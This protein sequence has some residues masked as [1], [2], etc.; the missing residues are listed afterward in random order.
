MFDINLHKFFLLQVLKEIYADPE[1][2][3]SLGFKGG[4][5][6]M[7]FHNLPRFSVDLDF[8][9]TG[10]FDEPEVYS[11]IR[12]ILKEFGNIRDEACKHYG[13]LLV[14]NYEKDNRNLKV[15]ISNR[16]YP[17]EYELRDYLGISMKVMKLEHMF[18]HKL[19]AILDR[20][21]LTNRDIFDC[22]YCMKKRTPLVKAIMDI[23]LKCGFTEY[24]DNCI[25]VVSKIN[26]NRILDGMG[27]LLDQETKTR[28][29]N[30]LI[31][32]FI[33]LARMYKEIPLLN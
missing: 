7:M 9:L 6:L 26:K 28:V 20:P 21:M 27:E 30:N 29:K 32:D 1:L 11:K 3:S 13:I 4:T 2:A 8:N 17:D 31:E 25:S 24:M 12:S 23:R 33:S 22:W 16:V 5:A 19:M 15:E 18:T 14:M 10:E